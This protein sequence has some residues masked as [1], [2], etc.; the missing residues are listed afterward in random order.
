M[1][2]NNVLFLSIVTRGTHIDDLE[3]TLTFVCDEVGDI[4]TPNLMTSLCLVVVHETM[5][6]V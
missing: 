2:T 4:D 6:I 1:M 5:V 3:E